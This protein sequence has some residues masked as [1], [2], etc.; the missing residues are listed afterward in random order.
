MAVKE[1][2]MNTKLAMSR[3][4]LVL[5]TT[6]LIALQTA[7]TAYYSEA[8]ASMM[9][10]FVIDANKVSSVEATQNV[11]NNR[12]QGLNLHGRMTAP[13]VDAA[14]GFPGVLDPRLNA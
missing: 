7:I 12:Y 3:K 6:S 4:L 5:T 14:R 8:E 1:T 11:E 13:Q 10:G 9:E 2:L